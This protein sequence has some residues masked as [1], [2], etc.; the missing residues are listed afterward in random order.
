MTTIAKTQHR[1]ND[2]PWLVGLA[3]L[4]A[5]GIAAWIVQL[6]Q[7]PMVLG[8]NQT[9]V[10]G[11]YIA[12]F[13][14][15]AGV[16][17]GLVILASLADLGT[18]PG[19]RLYRRGLLLG[20]LASFI[21][22]GFMIL[23][24]IGQPLRVLNIIFSANLSSPFV[25]D[26]ASLAL[27][28]I[29]AA[30]YL[31][32]KPGGKWL[33][34]IAG[35][36]AALLIIVEGWILSM[37]VAGA[38]WHGGM[39]PVLFLIEG[40]MAAAAITLMVQSDAQV[41]GWLRSV[42]LALLPILVVLNF[43]DLASV[44]YAGNTDAQAATAIFLTGNLAPLFWGH[45]LLGIVVPFVILAATRDNR[46][47]LTIAAVLALL[48]VFAAKLIMLIAGQAIPFFQTEAVSYLP[49]LVEVAGVFGV[50][51]LAGLLFM[52]GKRYIAPKAV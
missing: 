15:L 31:F 3:I 37:S 49:T 8:V 43:L 41:S 38:L 20:A 17:G 51:A 11:V 18:I 9:I 47:A 12:T 26:F 24:D 23:M 22:S 33:P 30:I 34:V 28:V 1:T 13:L 42:L 6:T 36:V 4:T 52:I 25:W 14:F 46:T 50:V 40:V 19:L 2:M 45:I 7:G 16:G 48:G 5:I 39:I 10:W 27:S 32:A 35:S 21:A 44:N 29:V